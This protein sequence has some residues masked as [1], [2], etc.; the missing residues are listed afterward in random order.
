[1]IEIYI[2]YKGDLHCEARHGPSGRG[3][4]TDAPLD[5]NGRG[6][7]FSPTD[8]LATSLGTCMATVLGIAGRRKDIPLEGMNVK[9]RKIMSDDQPRRVARLEVDIYV[10]ISE[11]HVER[12]LLQ[13]TALGCP[14]HH[15]IHP[16]IAV[17]INWFWAPD[18]ESDGH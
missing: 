1:M 4:D 18:A 15:S 6:E 2:D 8:L 11:D 9:V 17:D 14:V 16:D 12:R 7:S 13:S 5:N 10:P 3:L